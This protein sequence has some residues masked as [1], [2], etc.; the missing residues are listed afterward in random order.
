[1]AEGFGGNK[2]APLKKKMIGGMMQRQVKMIPVEITRF[3]WNVLT[4]KWDLGAFV[5][6]GIADVVCVML[7]SR[8]F[9]TARRRGRKGR[10]Q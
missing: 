3:R 8:I 4:W 2:I 5:E 7:W 10:M 6:Q 1:M 9:L